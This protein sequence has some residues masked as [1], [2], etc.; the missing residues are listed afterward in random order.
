VKRVRCID[1]VRFDLPA[2]GEL[3]RHGFGACRLRAV[4][5]MFKSAI[6]EHEC[7][8]FVRADEQTVRGR[9]G[10]IEVMEKGKGDGSH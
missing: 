4:V 7:P 6:F 2:E 8:Q 10:R 1:C 5:A 3:T 9:L